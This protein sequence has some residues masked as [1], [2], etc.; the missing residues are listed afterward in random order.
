MTPVRILCF[1]IHGGYSRDG[2]RDLARVHAL[3]ETLNIDIGCFQEMET[4]PLAR[5]HI[6]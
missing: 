5:W 4:R 6:V 3:M 1:N 2:K